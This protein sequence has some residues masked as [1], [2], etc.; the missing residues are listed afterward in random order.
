MWLL[1]FSFLIPLGILTGANFVVATALIEVIIVSLSIFTLVFLIL[2]NRISK[3]L[4]ILLLYSISFFTGMISI[5][6]K[7][8]EVERIPEIFRDKDELMMIRVNSF[9][10]Y[11]ADYTTFS[12]EILRLF[13]HP[14]PILSDINIFV[15]INGKIKSHLNQCMLIRARCKI[16]DD[17]GT[18]GVASI[19]HSLAMRGIKFVC[20]VDFRNAVTGLNGCND[21]FFNLTGRISEKIKN[22]INLNYSPSVSGFLIAI[23]TGDRSGISDELWNSFRRSGTAHLIAISGLH[24]GIV[25]AFVYFVFTKLLSIN[26]SFM[27]RFNIKRLSSLL[28]IPALIIFGILSGMSPST[29]RAVIMGVMFLLSI[30]LFK[31]PHTIFIT[32]FSW[33]STLLISPSLLFD[34][35]FQL[36][37]AAVFAIILFFSNFKIYRSKEGVISKIFYFLTLNAL[38]SIAGFAGTAGII[39][40]NFKSIPLFF[41][42]ANIIAVPLLTI[43]MPFLLLNLCLSFIPENLNFL[44]MLVNATAKVLLFNV[45]FWAGIKNSNLNLP[46]LDNFEFILYYS[47]IFIL[48]IKISC[49]LKIVFFAIFLFL[50][51]FHNIEFK[52]EKTMMVSFIDVGQG[53]STLIEFPDGENMLVDCGPEYRDFNAGERIVAP[54]LWH[55]GIKKI[56]ILAMTHQQ[57]DHIGGCPYIIEHF[58]VDE[59]WIS[60]TDW[61]L[62]GFNFK[63]TAVIKLH[64]GI[65]KNFDKLKIIS[66]NPG[67]NNNSADNN[68]SLVIKI[69]YNRFAILLTGDIGKEVE[70]ILPDGLM[71]TILKVP[72]HGSCTSS[73]D[74]F[75]NSVKPEIAVISAGRRNRFHH[76]CEKTIQRLKESTDKI[77]VT[78]SDG[79]TTVSTD[80]ARY[81]VSTFY[82][83][84]KIRQGQCP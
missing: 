52:K 35:S 69:E 27:K 4:S 38:T 53:D 74:E 48:L 51:T 32:C 10:E 2:N 47:L 25:G 43:L 64:N 33:S 12:A 84:D 46:P 40:K 77:Y 3:I 79:T 83:P 44:T 73:T 20:N 24:V 36:S 60:D 45:D 5:R 67:V 63:N 78:A 28:T 21:N 31:K 55:K 16:P 50:Y 18:P 49:R 80:G 57:S 8:E 66:L 70:K 15:S 14:E 59:I 26:A 62:E 81:C 56:N 71:S 7:I 76:P 13:N 41:L 6:V 68:N 75:L 1:P 19:R 82:N 42:P 34:L 65:I 54:F 72:H 22:Y 39:I 29:I 17:Y 58:N 37:Y 23:I 11:G 30:A 61:N 9:P